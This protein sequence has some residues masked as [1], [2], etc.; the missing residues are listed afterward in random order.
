[1]KAM[2]AQKY[3]HTMYTVVGRAKHQ[4]WLEAC[5]VYGDPTVY[6]CRQSKQ[7]DIS[8]GYEDALRTADLAM[9]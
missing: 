1:M 5:T 8:F 6:S 4:Y 3:R 9:C 7:Q 2:K